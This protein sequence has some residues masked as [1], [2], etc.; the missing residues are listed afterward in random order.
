MY[1]KLFISQYNKFKGKLT[2]WRGKIDVT[3]QCIEDFSKSTRYFTNGG[4]SK[5]LTGID[6]INRNGKDS[7]DILSEIYENDLAGMTFP[8]PLIF[9]I[10]EKM[11]YEKLYIPTKNSKDSEKYKNSKDYLKRLK[12]ALELPN[13]VEE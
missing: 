8:D 6:K 4:F 11:I 9:I 1:I 10:K 12:E 13:E 5:L 3:D 2:F 7:I